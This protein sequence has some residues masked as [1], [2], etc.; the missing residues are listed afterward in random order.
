[1]IIKGGRIIEPRAYNENHS[2]CPCPSPDPRKQSLLTFSAVSFPN[3]SI[4]P[5]NI[6]T[7]LFPDSS[8]TDNTDFLSCFIIIILLL[9]HPDTVLCERAKSLQLCP[10]LCYPMDCSPPGSSVHRNFPG[11]STGVGC[12]A[13]LQG[14]FPTQ[15]SNLRFYVSCFG[16]RV[17]YHQRHLG[18]QSFHT[19]VILIYAMTM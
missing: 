5:N 9:H 8:I 13:L 14:I 15:G 2:L 18:S 6:H 12:H 1:M 19:P 10:T 4:C 11:K 17:L 3:S 7:L 16:R